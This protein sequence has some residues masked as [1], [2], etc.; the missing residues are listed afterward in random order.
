MQLIILEGP[1]RKG[2]TTTL[3]LL[4][5]ILQKK[6]ASIIE[7]KQSLGGASGDYEVILNYKGY[8]IGLYT[9]GDYSNP[10]SKAI[11]KYHKEHK[12]D[13]FIFALSTDTKKVNAN[14]KIAKYDHS[15]HLKNTSIHKTDHETLNKKDAEYLLSLI[16]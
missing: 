16:N 13:Y 8:K 6:G 9:M 4:F 12:C 5:D 15:R 10:L 2:K 14:N 3:H 1:S 11:S 7:S